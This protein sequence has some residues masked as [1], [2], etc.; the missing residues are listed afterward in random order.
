MEPDLLRHTM[1][2]VR[3]ACTGVAEQEFR[4]AS[5]KI[6]DIGILTYLQVLSD[7]R[8][9]TDAHTMWPVGDIIVKLLTVKLQ[10][11]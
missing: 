11:I 1:W 4:E 7:H 5:T 10:I 8:S 3:C 6:T 9:P 2:P